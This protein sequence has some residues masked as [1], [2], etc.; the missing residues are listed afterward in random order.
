M[1]RATHG[2][3]AEREKE[4]VHDS[5]SEAP[6]AGAEFSIATENTPASGGTG[7]PRGTKARKVEMQPGGCGGRP[8]IRKGIMYTAGMLVLACTG[9]TVPVRGDAAAGPPMTRLEEP[10]GA[11][12]ALGGVCWDTCTA[13]ACWTSHA[14]IWQGPGSLCAAVDCYGACCIAG[15]CYECDQALCLT[16]YSG[17][18]AGRAVTS[19][20]ARRRRAPVASARGHVKSFLKV[21]A[22]ARAALSSA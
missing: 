9:T 22:K 11:C 5:A 1:S 15:A 8:M 6:R 13:A 18:A 20:P 10:T 12:C 7:A 16:L 2:S 19:P 21:R 4:R 17:R 3:G 14:G